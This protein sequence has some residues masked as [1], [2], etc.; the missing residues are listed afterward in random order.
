[1]QPADATMRRW[2]E[3]LGY[4]NW[5]L[6]PRHGRD[7]T[8]VYDLL[9]DRSPT[10]RALY[11]NLGYWRSAETLDEACDALASLVAETAGMAPG[12][13]VLDV[14]FGFADQDMLWAR[15]F[16]PRRIIGLNVTASQVER[17][18]R[19]VAEAGFG[20]QID[21]RLGS[22]TR[23][24][25]EAA[26]VDKVVALECAFHFDTRERFFTEAFRVLRPGGRLVVADILPMP[27]AARRSERLAQRW[28]WRQAARKFLIPDAN[29]YTREVYGEKLA[30]AGFVEPRMESI[31]DDVYLPLHR[32]LAR[33]RAAV[34]RLHPL[35][36]VPVRIAL[37]L[38]PGLV[39]SGLDY[40]LASAEKPRPAA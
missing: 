30:A 17:A 22:A 6:N 24:P 8:Q 26:S 25:L 27:P 34:A 12:D 29:A 1:M 9:S 35:L 3:T 11:L 16:R 21:L 33:D 38:D 13:E 37:R 14:G 2:R 32:Y 10:E 7:V 20:E 5:L 18:R 19:R 39:F 4:V 28:G 36:R 23:M 31:R 40:V 15:T